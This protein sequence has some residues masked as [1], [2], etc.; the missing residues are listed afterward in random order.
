VDITLAP[1]PAEPTP[2][3]D[4]RMVPESWL[5]RAI[6]AAIKAYAPAAQPPSHLTLVKP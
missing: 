4:E 3:Q 1:E 2:D 5:E 6:T